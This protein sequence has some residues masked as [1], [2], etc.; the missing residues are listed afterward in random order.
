MG[1]RSYGVALLVGLATSAAALFV[2]AEARGRTAYD[3][4][5]GYER[6]W[7]SA[8]RLVRVDLGLKVVEKDDKSGY[9]LFEYRASESQKLTSS[10][11][12]ELIRGSSP[13]RPDEGRVVA[14]RA[15]M[16]A[17][18][19]QV[20]LDELARKIRA[21]YGDAPEPRAPPPAPDAGPDGNQ[22]NNCP[23]PRPRRPDAGG[24]A[25]HVGQARRR[26]RDQQACR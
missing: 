19:E 4:P 20:F 3:S 25:C 11:S 23:A 16:P 15:Q 26:E 24:N 6:T 2:G 18:P 12:F 10:G 17:N 13:A 21:E 22:H 9:L 8:L 5:Y 1:R 14:Q 7:N